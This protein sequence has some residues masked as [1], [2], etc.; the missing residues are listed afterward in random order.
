M[1]GDDRQM[2]GMEVAGEGVV[3]LR[4]MSPLGI[5]RKFLHCCIE[6]FIAFID[7]DN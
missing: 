1:E 5:N 2:G 4:K 7:S 6:I 3:P